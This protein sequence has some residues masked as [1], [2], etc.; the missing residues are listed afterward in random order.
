MIIDSHQHVFWHN[1]NDKDLVL[2]MNEQGIDKAWLL[3][4]KIDQSEDV[5][6]DHNT[7]NPILLRPDGTHPGILFSDLL[8]AKRNYPERFILGFCPNPLHKNAAS[9]FEAAYNM[10]DVRI[11]GEWKHRML[12]DDPRS[13][14]LFRKAGELKCPVVIHLDVPY[15]LDAEN[16]ELVYQP[17]WYGGT[18]DN[19]E[20]ALKTCPDTIFL[21]HGPGFWR[22]ISGDSETAQGMYPKGALTPGG[23]LTEVLEENLNLYADLSAT[24]AISALK[25]DLKYTREFLCRY[26]DRILFARDY[27]GGDLNEFLQSLDLPADVRDKIYFSNAQKLIQE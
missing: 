24:S 1:K 19:L 3:T 15:L 11:C 23:R 26:S 25:R 21:G 9:R 6:Y 22:E 20:R 14:E 5:S 10:Y 13:I 4:W 16:G 27:Y 2:D 18:I 17:D 7:L 12:I 8:T